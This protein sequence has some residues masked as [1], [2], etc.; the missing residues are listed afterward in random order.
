MALGKKGE[1]RF[2]AI[3][4]SLFES[5]FDPKQKGQF[6]AKLAEADA[7]DQPKTYPIP[8]RFFT[9]LDPKAQNALHKVTQTCFSVAEKAGISL[10]HL[11][12]EVEFYGPYEWEHKTGESAFS[13]ELPA[14]KLDRS[15]K[16]PLIQLI[17]PDQIKNSEAVIKAVRL[18]ASKLFGHLYFEENVAGRPP[19][20]LMQ[21]E[22][23]ELSFDFREK[24][25]Y[26]RFLDPPSP[27]LQQSF[28]KEALAQG[29]RGPKAREM[30]KREWFKA[31][32]ESPETRPN[33]AHLIEDL[34][35]QSLKEL[36][37]NPDPYLEALV[38]KIDQHLPKGGLILPHEKKH[39]E[40]FK[41]AKQWNLFHAL[42]DRLQLVVGFWGEVTECFVWLDQVAAQ[43]ETFDPELARAWRKTLKERSAQLRKRGLVKLFL[44]EGA[45]LNERQQGD[46]NRFPLWV[47]KQGLL[48]HL[49]AGSDPAK[50]IK[51]YQDQYG[52]SLYAKLFELSFRLVEAIEGVEAQG[53]GRPL[54]EASRLK[55]LRTSVSL[56]SE[57]LE[58]LLNTTRIAF[59]LASVAKPKKHHKKEILKNYAEG[60]AYFVSFALIHQFY[61]TQPQGDEKA[62]Q[63]L[64]LIGDYTQAKV[65]QEPS[66]QIAGLLLEVYKKK[67][68]TLTPVV[69]LLTKDSKMLDFFAIHQTELLAKKNE[70][71]GEIIQNFGGL[72][73]KWQADRFKNA[74][75][76]AQPDGFEVRG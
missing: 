74:I 57:G 17:L 44:M 63:F 75:N 51:R 39:F 3:G 49:P 76:R 32:L 46:K 13:M 5:R 29:I 34:F 72:V 33:Q 19:F 14:A 71:P 68:F 11:S 37:A 6:A 22:L 1:N 24:L 40:F 67:G 61:W 4:D 54:K 20:S 23:S 55:A 62:L 48:D 69:E 12:P 38:S 65:E 15:G 66:Y 53:P 56:L 60:W 18:L 26:V 41:K 36:K 9:Q 45:Q 28:D 70:Q 10:K 35:A 2:G 27:A 16:T 25:L 50:W 59:S 7:K 8:V 21:E 52:H 73:E 47:W 58:D 31:L 42:E 64:N 43:E 30:G